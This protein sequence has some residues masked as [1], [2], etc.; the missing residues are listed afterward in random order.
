MTLNRGARLHETPKIIARYIV[1]KPV[2]LHVIGTFCQ[3]TQ[4]GVQEKKIKAVS[5]DVYLLV[6]S[7]NLK[8]KDSKRRA[9]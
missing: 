5:Y 8:Q 4:S 9:L 1:Y 3:T 6:V 2:N 7:K